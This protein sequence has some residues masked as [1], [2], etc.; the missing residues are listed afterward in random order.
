M[1]D[2]HQI[3]SIVAWPEKPA[4]LE[5]AFDKPVTVVVQAPPKDPLNVN[6]NMQM[7]VVAREIIPVC[8]KLCEPIC[9]RSDYTIGINIFDRPVAAITI[10][11]V[12][13]LF[14]CKEEG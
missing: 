11:G 2:Q 13:R 3:V 9:A 14:N 6:M 1:A 12:T 5:H 7:N 4:K 8:I 10:K